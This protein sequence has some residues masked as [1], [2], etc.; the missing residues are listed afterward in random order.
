M[1]LCLVQNDDGSWH[2]KKQYIVSFENKIQKF[3]QDLD[4]IMLN[5]FDAEFTHYSS[6]SLDYFSWD[7]RVGYV[8][9]TIS[10]LCRW[11]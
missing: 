7:H 10:P 2:K 11:Y 4:P 5:L 1:R 6:N 3:I 9:R 8:Y